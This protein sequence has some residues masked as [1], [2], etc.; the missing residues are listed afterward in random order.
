[1][2]PSFWQIFASATILCAAVSLSGC[3]KD[4]DKNKEET[5]EEATFSYVGTWATAKVMNADISTDENAKLYAETLINLA[6]VLIDEN[7]STGTE[8]IKEFVNNSVNSTI[9]F[10]RGIKISVKEEGKA[11]NVSFAGLSS[12]VEGSW[13]E[14]DGKLQLKLNAVPAAT[15]D[16]LKADASTKGRINYA[17]AVGIAGKTITLNRMAEGDNIVCQ[18]D[19]SFITKAISEAAKDQHLA[20]GS[21]LTGLFANNKTYNIEFYRV[22]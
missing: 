18:L 8:K 2:K 11:C 16:K 9:D 6:N 10:A 17:F 22:N 19:S 5:K 14:V 21:E 15:L 3:N 20:L 7:I 12:G 1:M 4:K 13:Q